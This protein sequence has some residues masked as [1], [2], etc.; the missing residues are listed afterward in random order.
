MVTLIN[1]STTFSSPRLFESRPPYNTMPCFHVQLFHYNCADWNEWKNW[2]E[3]CER[4]ERHSMC[5]F[6][7]N[8]DSEERHDHD[9][10]SAH[11]WWCVT[12]C[13][14]MKLMNLAR[15]ARAEMNEIRTR[16]LQFGMWTTQVWI[17]NSPERKKFSFICLMT[18]VGLLQQFLRYFVYYPKCVVARVDRLSDASLHSS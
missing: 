1:R 3:K 10:H 4:K 2:L 6:D 12:M 14:C 15:K 11:S 5:T 8:G 17:Q 7:T 9:H 13:A 16:K 18:H